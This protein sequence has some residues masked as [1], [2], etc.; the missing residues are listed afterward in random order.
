MNKLKRF[1]W[2][3]ALL[4]ASALAGVL[5][6][7]GAAGIV[8]VA[9]DV[10]RRQLAELPHDVWAAPTGDARMGGLVQLPRGFI[11]LG[12]EPL[13]LAPG[14]ILRGEGTGTVIR[15]L[16]TGKAIRLATAQNVN[17]GTNY[18]VEDLQIS[19]P[20]GDGIGFDA[21]VSG[22][23]RE[24]EIR[25][26]WFKTKGTAIDLRLPNDNLVYSATIE[27]I[28]IIGAVSPSVIGT[29]RLL[30]MDD[31]KFVN[32]DRAGPGAVIDLGS[33][34]TFCDGSLSRIW[35]EPSSSCVLIRLT[36]GDWRLRDNW[37]EPHAPATRLLIDGATVHA[38]FING[39]ST[40]PTKLLNG[41]RV[42]AD[43]VV[44]LGEKGFDEGKVVEAKRG[45]L[46]DESSRAY[47]RGQPVQ[48]GAID[49]REKS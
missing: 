16:G 27:H 47:E 25:H 15:Y 4:L 13:R 44:A 31:V 33:A 48:T 32:S 30:N 9:G 22:E 3:I 1:R 39:N 11:D 45:I 8:P 38:D 34:K 21:S 14:T 36:G 6:S 2:L 37:Y 40:Q 5:L 28:G 43:L 49:P 10:A 19:A 42:F 12:R 7:L 35:A 23:A 17:D 41:A 24:V 20:F 26:C 46:A 18:R 29:I